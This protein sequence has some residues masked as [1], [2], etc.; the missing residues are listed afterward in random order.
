MPLPLLI[1]KDK[2]AKILKDDYKLGWIMED[3]KSIYWMVWGS[4]KTYDLAVGVARQVLSE[5]GELKVFVS[6]NPV[7]RQCITSK[8]ECN[9]REIDIAQ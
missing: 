3:D 2:N 4:S 9:F 7:P 6:D 1:A 8:K 5:Q